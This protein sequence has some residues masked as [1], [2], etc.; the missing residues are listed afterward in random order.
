MQQLLSWLDAKLHRRRDIDTKRLYQNRLT[1]TAFFWIALLLSNTFTLFSLNLFYEK[2]LT[3]NQFSDAL[4]IF[5]TGVIVGAFVLLPYHPKHYGLNFHR[6]RYN[7]VWGLAFGGFG[8]FA[9]LGVRYL[10]LAW[11][12]ENINPSVEMQLPNLVRYIFVTLA[13]EIMIKGLF[14]SYFIALFDWFP[15]KKYLAVGLASLIFAQ[16]H[17]FLGIPAFL[18]MFGYSFLSG[19]WYERSRSIV[20]VTLLHFIVGAAIL[21]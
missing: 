21:Y 10:L 3:I 20:G 19:L 12:N 7:L 4:H 16:F 18:V 2:K 15:Y 9:A 6:F 13:E 1:K 5:M 14:Q 8:F 17:I 11:G